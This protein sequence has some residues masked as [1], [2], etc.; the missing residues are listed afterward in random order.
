MKKKRKRATPVTDF[1]ILPNGRVVKPK[2]NLRLNLDKLKP[3]KRK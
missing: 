1:V 3:V 2:K